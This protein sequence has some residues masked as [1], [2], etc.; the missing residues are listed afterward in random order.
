SEQPPGENSVS[1]P[2][3]ISTTRMRGDTRIRSG[4]P[5]DGLPAHFRRV[6][7]FTPRGGRLN[8]VQ[9]RAWEAHA[10]RW[11]VDQDD[12]TGP[13]DADAAAGLFGRTAPLVVEVGS[14]MGESTTEM[15]KARPDINLLAIEVYRPGVAQTFHHL[16]KAG[17]ENVRVMRADAVTV[18]TE[19]VP[20]GS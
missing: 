11:Y 9:R 8:D 4:A 18:L 15:A 16:A 19:L 13:L 5:D 2:R 1:Q 14:G 6:V 3:D 10:D 7:S 12:V 20:E 17:V